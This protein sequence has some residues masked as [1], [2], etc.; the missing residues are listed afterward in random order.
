MWFGTSNTSLKRRASEMPEEDISW[1][2]NQLLQRASTAEPSICADDDKNAPWNL[3]YEYCMK[4]LSSSSYA[5]LAYLYENGLG[6]TEKDLVKAA[7]YRLQAANTGHASSAYRL[8]VEAS[9]EIERITWLRMATS[10][11][12]LK[13]RYELGKAYLKGK[14]VPQDAKEAMGFFVG[15]N[16][17]KALRRRAMILEDEKQCKEAYALFQEAANAGDHYSYFSM[18]E[19]LSDPDFP[20]TDPERQLAFGFLQRAAFANHLDACLYLAMN[21]FIGRKSLGFTYAQS[22]ENAVYWYE[23]AAKLQGSQRAYFRLGECHENGFFYPKNLSK[24]FQMFQEAGAKNDYLALLQ[25]GEIYL[26]G[27]KGALDEGKKDVEAEPAVGFTYLKRATEHQAVEDGQGWFL[28][29]KCHMNGQG[30]SVNVEEALHCWKKAVKDY[31]H[32]AAKKALQAYFKA[33]ADEYA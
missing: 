26:H 7:G 24:A 17:P 2:V 22:Y 6:G 1:F 23:R 29:G 11:G 3:L 30:T 27:M 16:I 18:Y 33:K 15:C 12:H 28:L 19:L 10:N 8:S 5:A 20:A 14:G 9:S 4:N 13:A 25:L 32:A 31:S 21:Y